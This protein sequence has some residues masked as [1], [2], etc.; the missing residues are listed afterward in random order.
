MII[1][2]EGTRV[3]PGEKRR[4]KA[5]GAYLASQVG[6]QVV[7]VAHNAGEFWP[8]NA[9]LKYPGEVTVV[10]GPAVMPTETSTP[11]SLMQQVEAWIEARQREIGGV[12]PFADP[13]EKRARLARTAAA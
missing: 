3:A 5:G 9:F 10:I 6:C 11:D 1:F 8:R 12:G 13:E 2:P 7:P 4:Y